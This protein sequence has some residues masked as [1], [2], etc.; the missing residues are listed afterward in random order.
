MQKASANVDESS[1]N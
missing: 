1:G